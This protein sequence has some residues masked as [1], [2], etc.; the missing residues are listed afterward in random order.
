[1]HLLAPEQLK[2]SLKN[3]GGMGYDIGSKKSENHKTFE[4][5][6]IEFISVI[7]HFENISVYI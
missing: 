1:M 3:L 5:L 2:M 7:C 6:S 4:G